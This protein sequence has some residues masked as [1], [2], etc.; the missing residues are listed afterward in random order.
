MVSGRHFRSIE[1]SA[2]THFASACII[3]WSSQERATLNR[4]HS[5]SWSLFRERKRKTLTEVLNYSL[6]L[7]T[8]AAAASSYRHLECKAQTNPNLLFTP[9]RVQVSYSFLLFINQCDSGFDENLWEAFNGLTANKAWWSCSWHCRAGK[10]F[11]LRLRK[12]VP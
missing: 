4:N 9:N 7:D 5:A 11:L 8:H 10:N 3:A 1:V 6:K 12:F 2:P